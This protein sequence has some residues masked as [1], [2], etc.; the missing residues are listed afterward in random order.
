VLLN[1]QVEDEVVAPPPAPS[2][3]IPTVSAWGKVGMIFIL[4]LAGIGY[5]RRVIK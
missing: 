5:T 2:E 3:P 1:I 4:M